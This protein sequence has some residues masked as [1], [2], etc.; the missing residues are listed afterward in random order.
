[1]QLIGI[2]GGMGPE[3]GIALSKNIICN[4]IANKDQEHLPQILFSV[5]E[6]VPDRTDF[7]T[8]KITENPGY[9]IAKVLLQM[10]SCGITVA[11][12]ACNTA[13][14]PEIFD[15]IVSELIKN[16][17][18]LQLLHMIKETGKFIKEHYNDKKRVGILGTTGTYITRQYDIIS[19]Y[20]L[21]VLNISEEEQEQLQKAIYDPDYGIKA[22]AGNISPVTRQILTDS[23]MSLIGKGAELIILGC[24]E[25]PL[26][27]S[28]PRFNGISVIDP[29]VV[30]ARALIKAHSPEKLKPWKE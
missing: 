4:T 11:A 24:T 26:V 16:S 21:T 18:N 17:S 19:E 30:V 28:E 12:M 1:M 14:V 10:E 13:H 29:S 6:S 7:I 9:Q 25:L 3:A 22:N 8:G 15:V 27:F 5:P 20:G 2:L 23:I